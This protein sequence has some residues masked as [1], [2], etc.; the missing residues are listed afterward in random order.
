M[1]I[2]LSVLC[3]VM[4]PSCAKTPDNPYR[5]TNVEYSLVQ[6]DPLVKIM[7]EDK[8]VEEYVETADV[9]RGET[10]SFQLVF[11]TNVPVNDVMIEPGELTNGTTSIPYGIKAFEKY[12]RGGLH[13]TPAGDD[14]ILPITD[15][16]PDCLDETE[17]INVP[18]GFKQPIWV[19]Y[20]IPRDATPLLDLN[21]SILLYNYII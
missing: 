3:A 9:A 8:I 20:Q 10:V 12:I 21:S 13:L 11:K 15:E 19:T 6:V 16:Y 1:S 4:A 17:L 18:S 7:K 5:P 14:A 2:I